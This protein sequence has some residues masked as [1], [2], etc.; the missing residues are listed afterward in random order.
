MRRLRTLQGLDDPFDPMVVSA[1][2]GLSKSSPGLFELALALVP[3][4][5]AQTAFIDNDLEN[6]ARAT[7]CGIQ[8]IHFDESKNDVSGLAES[9][10][11]RFA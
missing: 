2:V 1:D 4:E 8:G 5:P 6:V 9:L 7:A 10:R 11:S 3:S